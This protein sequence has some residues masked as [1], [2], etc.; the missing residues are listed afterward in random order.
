MY[1][2]IIIYSLNPI[3][4]KFS[5][6]RCKNQELN[7]EN[8]IEVKPHSKPDIKDKELV[9]WDCFNVQIF[10]NE[11]NISSLIINHLCVTKIEFKYNTRELI[12][13]IDDINTKYRKIIGHR[14]TL[15]R[16]E[17]DIRKDILKGLEKLAEIKDE[18]SIINFKRIQ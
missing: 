8:I 16:T 13:I 18:K 12:F 17:L 4:Y 14:I 1:K 9:Y 15:K 7:C 10:N 2:E 6:N 3:K 5:E 11:M